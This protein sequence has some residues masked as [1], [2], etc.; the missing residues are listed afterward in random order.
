MAFLQNKF[1]HPPLLELE[2]PQGPK[3]P[4]PQSIWALALSRAIRAHHFGEPGLFSAP[5]LTALYRKPSV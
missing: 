1:R 2:E 4:M 5:K 3:G